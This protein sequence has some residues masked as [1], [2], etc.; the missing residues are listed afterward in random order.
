MR[1]EGVLSLDQRC[2]GQA[3]CEEE[4]DLKVVK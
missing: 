3:P 1:A 4:Q 2:G